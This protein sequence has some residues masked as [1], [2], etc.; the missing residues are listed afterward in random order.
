MENTEK[1]K[2]YNRTYMKGRR[3]DETYREKE[4][5]YFRE[6]YN[7]NGRNRSDNYVGCILEWKQGHPDSYKASLNLYYAVKIGKIIKP[8]ACEICERKTRLSG[9]HEDYSKPLEVI[10]LCSS[11]HK[12]KHFEEAA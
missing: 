11:C 4:R 2:A 12:L 9:H 6:W 5:A 8:A 10:W 3:L 1:V 7:E